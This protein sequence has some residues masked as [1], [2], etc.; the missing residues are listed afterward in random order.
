[1]ARAGLDRV[2]EAALS[3]P[4]QPR[5]TGGGL[6]AAVRTAVRQEP[7]LAEMVGSSLTLEYVRSSLEASRPGE[8]GWLPVEDRLLVSYRDAAVR[9]DRWESAMGPISPRQVRAGA[10]LLAVSLQR[11]GVCLELAVRLRLAVPVP[12][13]STADGL[14]PLLELVGIGTEAAAKAHAVVRRIVE[15]PDGTFDDD[16]DAS[17]RGLN[18]VQVLHQMVRAQFPDPGID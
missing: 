6:A 3:L 14:A 15:Q 10:G 9:I 13:R 5:A 11:D 12:H 2:A 18:L 8:G 16:V 17:R 7:W 1:M 4:S